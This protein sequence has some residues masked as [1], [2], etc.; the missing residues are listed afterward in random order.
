MGFNSNVAKVSSTSV[1]T[2]AKATVDGYLN[3]YLSRQDGSEFKIGF[4]GLSD[5]KEDQAELHE[6]IQE[7]EKNIGVLKKH[8]VLSFVPVTGTKASFTFIKKDK[9][10]PRIPVAVAK[11]DSPKAYINIY[12]PRTDGSLA[13]LGFIALMDT[14]QE[15]KM[16]LD[17]IQADVEAHLEV[18][19]KSLIIKYNSS[20]P[21]AK[22][23][24]S[25][26]AA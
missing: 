8:L 10:A 19:K 24:F 20:K 12:A 7:S 6:F 25:F 2:A 3:L 18:I 14:N 4:I 1:N 15:Q 22:A 5:S 16:L 21:V 17:Y 13:K 26:M 11:A 9:A 23:L